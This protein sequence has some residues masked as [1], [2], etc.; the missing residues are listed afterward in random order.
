[1]PPEWNLPEHGLPIERPPLYSRAMTQPNLEILRQRA[2]AIHRRYLANYAGQ[3]RISRDPDA[4][5]RMVKEM[6]DLANQLRRLPAV[7]QMQLSKVL[8]ENR[9]LYAQEAKAIREA[10]AGGDEALYSHHLA[11]QAALVSGRYRRH[12]AGR[13]R[14]TRDVGLLSEMISDLERL[15]PLMEEQLTRHPSDELRQALTVARDNLPLYQSELVEVRKAQAAGDLEQ[16]ADVLA[17]LANHQFELYRHHFAGHPRLS[18][19]PALL[20][21]LVEN[22][23][24][25]HADML[26]LKAQGLSLETNDKNADIVAG[27][28]AAWQTELTAV[29]DAKSRSRLEDLVNALGDAANA[30]FEQYRQNFAGQDR[31]TRDLDL[32]N[33]LTDA[34]IEIG[35]QMEDL[36]RVRDDQTNRTNLGIVLDHIR[37]YDREYDQIREAQAPKT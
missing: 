10:Q 24:R 14:A 36:D 29:R 32:L 19:R 18:R 3:P 6:D 30:V 27:R 4:L 23:E 12:F 26:A 28:I 22:L 9:D 31:A 20:S 34:L 13:G 5:Q 15:L 8:R 35:R 7:Q 21:R 1:M 2:D 17:S 11:T 16:Q 37:M 33:R 25:I